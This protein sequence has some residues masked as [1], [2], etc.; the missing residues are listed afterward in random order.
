MTH[1]LLESSQ[2][3]AEVHK[4]P[5]F[6]CH[7]L[8]SWQ[9]AYYGILVYIYI[10]LLIYIYIYTYTYTYKIELVGVFNPSEKL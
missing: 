10:Y 4:G 8:I 2:R 9:V 5:T 3:I 7:F 1:P 6:H